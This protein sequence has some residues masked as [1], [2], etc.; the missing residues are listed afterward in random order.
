M[1]AAKHVET[2]RARKLRKIF[3]AFSL[4]AVFL[5]LSYWW[6]LSPRWGYRAD[7][8]AISSKTHSA[9]FDIFVDA[10]ASE[11]AAQIYAADGAGRAVFPYSVIPGGI[12]SAREL[13]DAVQHDTVVAQHYRDFHLGTAH[14]ISLKKDS[15]AYVSYRLGD[16]IYWT[17]NKVT[18][19]AGETLLSDGN[20]V[21]RGRCGNRVSETPKSP[22]SSKEP[23]D[24]TMSTPA[25]VLEPVP[26][27]FPVGG[28]PL[29]QINL[30]TQSLGPPNIPPGVAF[31]PLFPPIF[32]GGHGSQSVPS[33]SP[34]PLSP[35]P[36]LVATPEP[37]SVLLVLLGLACL[38]A[39]GALLR[40]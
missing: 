32:P 25:F 2:R 36:P 38:G 5:A 15:Q 11:P 21:A 19:H 30:P 8:S 24:R 28:P 33:G 29:A 10:S 6:F 13:A 12:H 14:A 4:V 23:P 26:L 40:K 3:P 31:P 1:N 22:V 9:T 39:F 35:P 27:G 7:P 34:P 17:R 37:A 16:R 20:N 18:L